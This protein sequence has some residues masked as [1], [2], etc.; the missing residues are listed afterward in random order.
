MS[1]VRNL[2]GGVFTG[3]TAFER[4]TNRGGAAYS[5]PLHEIK[6]FLVL[7]HASALGT[8]IHATPL[9]S[10]L[11][12]A[13]PES[14]IAVVASG[15]SLDVLRHNPNIDTLIATP[16]PLKDL[17]GA[18][19]SLRSQFPFHRA[20]FA[21]VTPMG[22]ER[23]R[24][25]LQALLSGASNRIGFTVQ[26]ELYRMPM[27]FDNTK[28]Q[29]A[30]NLRLV[31]ALG[32]TPTH[33][34]PQIFFSEHDMAVA[35]EVLASTGLENEQPVAVFI[36]QTSVTQRKSWRPERFHE[37]ATFLK[38]RHGAHILFVGTASESQTIDQLRLGLPFRT[39]SVAG[40]TTLPQLAALM[41]LCNVGVALDTGPMHVGRAAGLPMVIIAPAWSP[42]I[43]WLPLG[44]DKF[45]ILKNADMPSAPQ[46]YTIDEVSVD[47]VTSALAELLARYPRSLAVNQRLQSK[48]R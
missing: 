24:I 47:D 21:T 12:R 20:T 14:R 6:N 11:R 17:K 39:T 43:E 9:F 40:K 10:A 27:V 1:L 25:A 23:T 32:H 19:Q 35:Q 4:L 37:A 36:T 2:K 30:N 18:V 8:A 22:N 13:V 5:G 45:R 28:S 44:N 33:F 42:P 46:D 31:D 15:F 3:I 34:E 48:S 26:S 7:Q 29:I 38:E 41:S 16:S